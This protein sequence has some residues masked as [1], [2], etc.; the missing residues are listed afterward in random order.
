[1]KKKYVSLIGDQS[2]GFLSDISTWIDDT[3]HEKSVATPTDLT[4]HTVVTAM[5]NR[6]VTPVI[7]I[8]DW[9]G[10]RILERADSLKD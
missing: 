5:T 10:L 6:T 9:H 1:M 7:K 2:R 3:T 4:E 8:G